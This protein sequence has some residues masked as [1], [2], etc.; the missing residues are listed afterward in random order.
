[1]ALRS[2]SA[3]TISFGLVSIPIKL[4]SPKNTSANISFRMLH[5]KDHTRLRQQYVCP[6]DGEVVPNEER[7]KGYEIARDR[8]V[9]LTDEELKAAAAETS[10]TIAIHEFVPLSAVDPIYFDKAYYI[11]PDKGGG[12]AYKLLARALEETGLCGV[13]K[14]AA[15]G[16][17][18]LVLLRPMADGLVMQQLLHSDEVRSFDEVPVEDVAAIEEKELKLARQ[19]IEQGASDEFELDK[20]RD[21]VRERL[22]EIIE[23][24]VQG[25]EV[26]FGAPEEPRGQVIDLMEALKASL[27]ESETPSKKRS[28][29]KSPQKSAPKGEKKAK[30]KKASK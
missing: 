1:M 30:K 29:R 5:S 3:A 11:G 27:G 14:Y 4:Y 7:V 19:L 15:R 10:R 21:E 16:K 6:K 12:R 28:T 18:Y 8:Y 2:L 9:V 17:M 13:A 22:Q 23:Q 20:Y 26:T 24:K 25:E